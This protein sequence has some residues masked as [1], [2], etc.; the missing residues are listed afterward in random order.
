MGVNK[1]AHGS[2]KTLFCQKIHTMVCLTVQVLDSV[3]LKMTE[4]GP[5]INNNSTIRMGRVT[6]NIFRGNEI[7]YYQGIHFDNEFFYVLVFRKHEAML[8]A[9]Q[10]HCHGMRMINLSRAATNPGATSVSN[11]ASCTSTARVSS[12]RIIYVQFEEACRWRFPAKEMRGSRRVAPVGR[13]DEK[14]VN[15]GGG[16]PFKDAIAFKANF[17]HDQ[18]I[19]H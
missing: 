18:F 3:F 19:S 4:E 2:V 10:F 13:E 1:K 12:S 8:E 15:G 5:T 9:P 16:N 6:L 7:H 11:N 14:Q 17:F